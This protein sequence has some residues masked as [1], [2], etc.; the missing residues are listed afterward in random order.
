MGKQHTDQ[1]VHAAIVDGGN[2]E[3]GPLP[4]TQGAEVHLVLLHDVRILRKDKRRQPNGGGYKNALS[5][6][7]RRLFVN[8]IFPHCYM[9]WVSFLQRLKQQVQ[10]GWVLVIFLHHPRTL[11]HKH[12]HFKGLFLLRRFTKQVQ[13]KG[14]IQCDFRLLPKGV[15]GR[16]LGR[17]GIFYQ[18]IH[19]LQHVRFLT[20]IAE[21]V[22]AIRLTGMDQVKY[23]NIVALAFQE[24]AGGAQHFALLS[25]GFEIFFEKS[26]KRIAV[27]KVNQATSASCKAIASFV[28]RAFTSSSCVCFAFSAGIA[29]TTK[30]VPPILSTKPVFIFSTVITSFCK[31]RGVRSRTPLYQ[32]KKDYSFS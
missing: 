21:G 26:P 18:I 2:A 3:D 32:P 28:I 19:Q 27:R 9:G 10:W 20:D 13:H 15:V 17:R 30:I 11:Q 16:A 31:N 23:L 5:S 25:S 29:L 1:I 24:M 4:L 8:L 7:A 14:G 22:I 12:Q 6:L